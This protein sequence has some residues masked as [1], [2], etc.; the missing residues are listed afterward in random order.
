[1]SIM[2]TMSAVS[3]HMHQWA[4]K[5]YQYRQPTPQASQMQPMLYQKVERRDAQQQP[6]HQ[7]CA[8]RRGCGFA[9]AGK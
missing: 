5:K 2:P 9:L 1:M 7:T 6:E 4:G 8:P 3:E